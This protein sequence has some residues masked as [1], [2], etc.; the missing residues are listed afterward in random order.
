MT[1]PIYSGFYS[2]L[3]ETLTV[4]ADSLGKLDNGRYSID[5]DNLQTQMDIDTNALILCNPPNPT[6]NV[7][8]EE[9]L[10]RLGRMCLERRIVVLADEIHCDFVTEGSKYVP[11]ASLPDKDVVKNSISFKPSARRSAW[12]R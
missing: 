2:D 5:W 6:G 3:R 10:L 1:T 12:R 8:S 4:T 7:W 9:D 11:F